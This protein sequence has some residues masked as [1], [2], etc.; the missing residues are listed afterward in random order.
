MTLNLRDNYI[1]DL[2]AEHF[3]NAL[4]FNTVRQILNVFHIS[5]C[6]L[7]TDTHNTRF[8]IE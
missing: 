6:H 7:V 4:Q 3:A 8:E 5:L 1:G 2:G